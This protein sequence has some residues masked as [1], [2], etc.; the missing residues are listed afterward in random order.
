MI[1]ALATPRIAA[2]LEDGLERIQR[3]LREASSQGAAIVCFPEAY[4]PGLRG[5][6]FEVC[7]YDQ[8]Q[9]ERLLQT[10]SQLAR[11]YAIATIMGM[12]KNTEDG[13][14]IVACVFDA[15]GQVQGYQTKNQLDPTEDNE[16]QAGKMKNHGIFSDV[17]NEVGHIIVAEVQKDR[18]AELLEPDRRALMR[19]IDKTGPPP[20]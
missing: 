7:L 9:Q 11:T 8:L 3:L 1:I 12:E 16:Y 18:I 2:S 20:S 13:R 14:Q 5:L 4:L 15:Q 17:R 6:D 10:V 19:L